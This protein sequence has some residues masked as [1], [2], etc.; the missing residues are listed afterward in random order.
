MNKFLVF[1]LLF[2]SFLLGKGY[3]PESLTGLTIRYNE[4]EIVSGQEEDLG[5]QE[6]RFSDN[7]LSAWDDD[8]GAEVSEPYTYRKT[9]ESTGTL[10]IEESGEVYE[11][12]LTFTS[13]ES[14]KGTWTEKDEEGSFGGRL[15]FEIIDEGSTASPV[16]GG[17]TGVHNGTGKSPDNLTGLTIKYVEYENI[18]GVESR[19]GEQ[20]GKFSNNMLTA[21]DDDDKANVSEPYTYTKTGDNTGTLRI[22]EGSDVYEAQLTFDTDKQGNGTWTEKDEEGSFG[23]RL[24]FEIIDEGSANV[25]GDETQQPGNAK[26]NENNSPEVLAV[27]VREVEDFVANEIKSY[28]EFSG[29]K[30]I[31]AEK[32]FDTFNRERFVYIV[33]MDG[34]I[35]LYFNQNKKLVHAAPSD[36]YA[37]IESKFL[38]ESAIPQELKTAILAKL[39]M[40]QYLM[41]MKN[42]QF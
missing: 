38:P 4:I 21:W 40:Q 6:G 32:I 12:L 17:S 20:E 35:A 31:W 28:N 25:P 2:S 13:D 15:T 16:D 3:S 11:A 42:T 37:P 1:N 5:W 7:M 14:G 41:R 18:D 24:T 29:K 8:E 9:G 30:P 19:M 39:L 27:P 34:G 26:D 33:G 36:D 10:R 22:A 23:G